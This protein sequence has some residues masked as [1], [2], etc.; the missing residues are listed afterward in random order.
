MASERALCALIPA[1]VLQAFT[2]QLSN[3]IHQSK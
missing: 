1:T 3:N 2:T